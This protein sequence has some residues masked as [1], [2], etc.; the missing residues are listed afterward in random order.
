M[1]SSWVFDSSTV[2]G[3]G[4]GAWIEVTISVFEVVLA[5]DKDGFGAWFGRIS[6]PK[7]VKNGFFVAISQPS[8]L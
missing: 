8:P 3:L 5:D 2:D 7:E 4:I 1:V 6:A